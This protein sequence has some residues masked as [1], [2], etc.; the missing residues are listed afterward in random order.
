MVDEGWLSSFQG[1][2]GDV[3]LLPVLPDHSV[4]Q[5][6]LGP[7]DPALR[8]QQCWKFVE[9]LSELNSKYLDIRNFRLIWIRISLFRRNYSNYSFQHWNTSD[10]SVLFFYFLFLLRLIFKTRRFPDSRLFQLSWLYLEGDLL[11]YC[12]T[13]LLALQHLTFKTSRFCITSFASALLVGFWLD[14]IW[15]SRTESNVVLQ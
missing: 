10:W 5:A 12:L 8:T 11:N 7:D 4:H 15:A 3:H 14:F 9:N 13:V 2:V 1:A 6:H